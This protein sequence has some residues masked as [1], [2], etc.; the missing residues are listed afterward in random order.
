M[1]KMYLLIVLAGIL[2]AWQPVRANLSF[3]QGLSDWTIEQRQDAWP[4]TQ[5]E[6]TSDVVLDRA[7]EGTKSVRLGAKIVGDYSQWQD[8]DKTQTIAWY[9]QT[10][11][12][13]HAISILIDM[14][15]IQRAE[16]QSYWGWGMDADLILSDGVNETRAMLWNY[17]EENTGLYG[18]PGLEDNL[19]DS[20]I[21]GADGTQWLRYQMEL[22]PENWGLNDFGGGPLDILDLSAVK[23]GV[24]YA[25]ENWNS[26]PQTLWA[27]GLVDN[28]KVEYETIIANINVDPDTLNLKSKGSPVT[29]YTD[30]PF[31]QINPATLALNG[32]PAYKAQPDDG[33]NLFCQFSRA[34]I[35]AIVSPSEAE[36]VLTGTTFEGQPVIGTDTIRVINPDK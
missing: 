24:V 11:N 21:A 22:I 23:I 25:A 1:K 17:H 32:V 15:D 34:Q 4:G 10:F 12:L 7:S 31:A 3:E 20:I 19:F 30:I 2:F 35:Q 26:R 36:M 14:T 29:V 9:N 27:N 6:Y 28:I 33:G 16:P 8:I 13:T 5:H 18:P